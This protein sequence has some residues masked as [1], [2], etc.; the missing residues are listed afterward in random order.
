MVKTNNQQLR[1]EKKKHHGFVRVAAGTPKIRLADVQHN[2]GSITVLIGWAEEYNAKVLVLPELCLTGYTCGDLF[3]HDT[4]LKEAEKGL[5]TIA[6]ST[7]NKNVLVFMGLPLAVKGKIYNVVA[8]LKGGKILGFTTKTVLSC[9][10]GLDEKRYFTPGPKHP[11]TIQYNQQEI[12]FGSGLL[13]QAT[14]M[15][16]LIVAAEIGDELYALTPISTKVAMEGATLLANS[17]AN[18]ES[19]GWEVRRR[20]MIQNQS[21]RLLLATINA[22]AGEGESTSDKVFGGG[23][24][25]VEGG[26]I[27]KE[28]KKYQSGIIYS[29]VDIWKMVSERRKDDLYQEAEEKKLPIIPFETKLDGVKL[30]RKFW[31]NPFV[32]QN[33]L[34]RSL[35]CE[36]VFTIQVMGLKQ[37]I[38]QTGAKTAVVGISG[39]LDSTLALL[40]VARAFALSGRAKKDIIAVT[41]P[42]FGTT[43][44]TRKNAILL[45][46]KLGATLKEVPINDAV[47][48]HFADI[49]HDPNQ[50][51]EVYEKSQVRKRNQILLDI[52]AG[53]RGLVVGTVDM[54][55]LALGWLTFGGDSVAMYGVN[56]SVP[57][58][59]VRYLIQFFAEHISDDELKLTLQD[60]LIT[61]ISSELLPPKNEHD[62]H[63]TERTIGPYELNDFFLYYTLRYQFSPEKIFDLAVNTFGDRYNEQVIGGWM[64]MFY[65]RFFTQ[66]YKRSCMPEGPKVGK[67]SLSPRGELQMPSEASPRLWLNA[68][69]EFTEVPVEEEW[70][71]DLEK[72]S[73]G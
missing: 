13:F 43:E 12:P 29:E 46:K 45:A 1:K 69:E 41:M 61:P 38:E 28:G 10:Y 14:T 35:R 67:V 37:R 8:T 58:T 54:S 31:H 18:D 16:E 25:I 42:G 36:E 24:L 63:R 44:R 70:F 62:S 7:K 72:V 6:E 9:C 17:S 40:V 68:V 22:N 2:I 20:E 48:L 39:G 71:S 59:L 27:L 60:I 65:K 4:L 30:S 66:Q 50:F 34:Q 21:S 47:N 32:P 5:N 52:A 49:G 57:K 51:D 26:D 33:K 53:N 56:V 3:T 64:K 19:I 73:L 11:T 55:E 15:K 23:S